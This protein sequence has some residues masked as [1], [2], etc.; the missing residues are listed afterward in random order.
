[1]PTLLHLMGYAIP[2]TVDGRILTE[3]LA[4]AP[5]RPEA[6]AAPLTYYTEARTTAGVYRQHLDATRVGSTVY[7]E[8]GWVES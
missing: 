8:H 5:D 4:A 2:E 7:L 6:E 3:S 1:M